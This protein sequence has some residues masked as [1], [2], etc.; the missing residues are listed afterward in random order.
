MVASNGGNVSV[1][2][3]DHHFQLGIVKLDA[4]RPGERP[5]MDSVQGLHVHEDRNSRGATHTTDPHELVKVEIQ[6]MGSLDEV[7]K[8]LTSATPCAVEMG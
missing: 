7:V 2:R 3:K 6:L 4:C 8:H 1:T 5:P